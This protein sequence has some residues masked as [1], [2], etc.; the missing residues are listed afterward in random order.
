MSHKGTR[1]RALDGRSGEKLYKTYLIRNNVSYERF[2]DDNSD[3]NA[4]FLMGRR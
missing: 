3:G 2:C 4:V 1:N